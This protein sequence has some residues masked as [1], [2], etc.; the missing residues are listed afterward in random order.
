[1]AEL[2][3]FVSLSNLS[4][5]E[6]PFSSIWF[7]LSSTPVPQPQLQLNHQPHIT[8]PLKHPNPKPPFQHQISTKPMAE[9][10]LNGSVAL[11][12]APLASPY[13]DRLRVL[14][15]LCDVG[16]VVELDWGW[17]W[18]IG[19]EEIENQMEERESVE[20][21]TQ[22]RDGERRRENL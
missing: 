4:I 3:L 2:D 13:P 1:M 11:G 21:T 7:S 9:I 12:V 20:E 22:M 17:G 18:G 15:G 10:D 6:T 14:E 19:V 8:Q 5:A 16:L